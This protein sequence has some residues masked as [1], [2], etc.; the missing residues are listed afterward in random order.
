M[1]AVLQQWIGWLNMSQLTNYSY[2]MRNN[3]SL[4]VKGMREVEAYFRDRSDT[5]HLKNLQAD[6]QCQTADI[7][8]LWTTRKGLRFST[9]TLEVKV[10]NPLTTTDFFLEIVSN[11]SKQTPGA[12]VYSF[13][14]YFVYL[15]YDRKE[16]YLIPAKNMKLWMLERWDTLKT[17]E[18]KTTVGDS[19]YVT[20]GKIASEADIMGI[21]GVA[22]YKLDYEIKQVEPVRH[23]RFV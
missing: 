7:D 6:K 8:L 2:D 5:I 11:D 20:K 1:S 16:L 19:H 23:L 17:R 15:F 10:C 21:E 3:C 9:Y 4:E 14:D 12:A 13:A 18:T 22:K